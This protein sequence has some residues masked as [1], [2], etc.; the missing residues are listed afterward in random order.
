MLSGGRWGCLDRGCQGW[1][2]DVYPSADPGPWASYPS[3]SSLPAAPAAVPAPSGPRLSRIIPG[4][5]GTGRAHLDPVTGPGW[6]SG[7]GVLRRQ[8][9]A[10]NEFQS[11]ARALA[12]GGEGRATGRA[13]G[14]WDQSWRTSGPGSGQDGGISSG[15]D[16]GQGLAKVAPGG[17]PAGLRPHLPGPLGTGGWAG[18]WFG[19]GTSPAEQV[20]SN[21]A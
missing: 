2:V 3:P 20:K 10:L 18:I 17:G 12:W 16:A 6:G 9:M 4:A 21:S 5:L 7:L 8:S 1:G 19:L 11:L 14:R 13:G 15:G